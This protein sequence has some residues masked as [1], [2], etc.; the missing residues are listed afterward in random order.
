MI[1]KLT[2][3][4]DKIAPWFESIIPETRVLLND[5]AGRRWILKTLGYDKSFKLEDLRTFVDRNDLNNEYVSRYKEESVKARKGISALKSEIS[6]LY[7]FDK[8]FIQRYKGRLHFYRDD[9][10]QKGARNMYPVGAAIGLHEE[11]KQNL[12]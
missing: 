9:L 7:S 8:C 1:K 4:L 5:S 2:E 3:L 6:A 12:D 11:F 10:S